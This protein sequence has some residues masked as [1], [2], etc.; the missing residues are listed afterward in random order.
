MNTFQESRGLSEP[1]SHHIVP[2]QKI[3]ATTGKLRDRI[4]IYWTPVPEAR[5]YAVYRN[6]TNSPE[7]AVPIGIVEACQFDDVT[8]EKGKVYFYWVQSVGDWTVSEFSRVELGSR[9]YP[10]GF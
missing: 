4:S 5:E 8:T 3:E 10:W 1:E 2:P 7:S 9:G 6:L